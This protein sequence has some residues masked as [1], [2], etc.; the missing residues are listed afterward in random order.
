MNAVI[1]PFLINGPSLSAVVCAKAVAEK[2]HLSD[3]GEAVTG[4]RRMGR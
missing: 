3:A 1:C 2:T 4:R